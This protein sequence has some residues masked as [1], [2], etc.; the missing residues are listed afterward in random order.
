[1]MIFALVSL[2]MSSPMANIASG[3]LIFVRPPLNAGIPIDNAILAVGN[4][5]I[6]WLRANGVS[7]PT[8]ETSV[9]V[10][11]AWRNHSA[12]GALSLTQLL[13]D[14]LSSRGVIGVVSNYSLFD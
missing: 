4:A 6:H 1:M 5:T 7:V 8:N 9:H 12:G 2:S 3:D 10:A 11:I 13:L 14:A